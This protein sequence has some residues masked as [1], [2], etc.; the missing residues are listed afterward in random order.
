[1]PQKTSPNFIWFCLDAFLTCVSLLAIPT[2][3]GTP[4]TTAVGKEH[5]IIEWM[6]PESDGGSEIKT[7]MVDKR[8]KSSTRSDTHFSLPHLFLFFLFSLSVKKGSPF[9]VFSFSLSRWTR[10]N[11]TF[12][13]YDTR[14]KIT[15]LLEGSD[16]QFR[17]MA[18]NAA[19]SSQPSDASP[20]ILCKDPTCKEPRLLFL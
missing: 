9:K 13:I 19:G 3:P 18:I 15:G 4:E 6:K 1:M 11:K 17:V 8:E 16:Y 2:P 10:V 7:Y 5:V 20:Y 14:L 12:T